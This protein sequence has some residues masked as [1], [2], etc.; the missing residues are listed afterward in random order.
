MTRSL[1]KV[2]GL[3]Q[4][5][6]KEDVFLQLHRSGSGLRRSHP[7]GVSGS[8]LP[9]ASGRL[10][11]RIKS[12][13][14]EPNRT[15][16]FGQDVCRGLLLAE[17]DPRAGVASPP[18]MRPAHRC[19]TGASGRRGWGPIVLQ[20][21][22]CSMRRRMVSGG[23]FLPFLFLSRRRL[24]RN[25]YFRVSAGKTCTSFIKFTPNILTNL[26]FFSPHAE[27]SPPHHRVLLL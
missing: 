21:D 9:P 25:S 13:E 3:A 4:R 5:Q 6:R 14:I 24:Y 11:A 12:G 23:Q 8:S 22:P 20:R 18:G 2:S 10:S 26:D 1:D 7:P 27:C 15:R 17:V 16:N 19:F